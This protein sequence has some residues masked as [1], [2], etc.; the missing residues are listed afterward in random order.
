MF[1]SHQFGRHRERKQEVS[2]NN[3]GKVDDIGRNTDPT[4]AH[5]SYYALIGI[6][7]YS[8]LLLILPCSLA[9]KR[10]QTCKV[11][12]QQAQKLHTH[13]SAPTQRRRFD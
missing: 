11:L 6:P 4:W 1:A 5:P 9:Y 3:P 8:V 12:D 2:G 13:T 10:T 7:H